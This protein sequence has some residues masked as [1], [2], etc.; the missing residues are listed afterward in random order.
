AL[1]PGARSGQEGP[2]EL[3]ERADG[4]VGLVGSGAAG[5]RVQDRLHPDAPGAPDVGLEA[6]AHHH[7]LGGGEAEPGE[8]DPEER[9]FRL[10][11]DLRPPAAG[12]RHRLDDRAAPGEEVAPLDRQPRIDVRRD[13]P[14]AGRDRARRRREPRVREVEVVADRHDRRLP[15]ALDGEH[16]VPGGADDR[17]H[18]VGPDHEHARAPVALADELPEDLERRQDALA[19]GL[20]AERREPSV[21]VAR[22]RAR[23]VREEGDPPRAPPELGD[24]LGGARRHLGAGPDAAVEV[25]DDAA[26]LGQA[27]AAGLSARAASSTGPNSWTRHRRSPSIAARAARSPGA[28]SARRSM[29]RPGRSTP[30]SR[31]SRSAAAARHARRAWTRRRTAAETAGRGCRGGWGSWSAGRPSP[32][33]TVDR[34]ASPQRSR[35]RRV[36]PGIAASTA[37]LPGL[38]AAM[39]R[40]VSL[41]RI[42]NGGRPVASAAASRNAWSSRRIARARGGSARAPLMSK[43]ASGSRSRTGG[44]WAARAAHSSSTQASRAIARSS[45]SRRSRSGMR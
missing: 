33:A 24:Q 29:S 27:H 18:F 6:V 12:D 37:A 10:A 34:I 44:S 39:S 30:G 1:R 14:G 4:E 31:A 32:R 16:L 3:D 36:Q 41:P 9:R 38:A 19:V 2:A 7:R 42:L 35:T 45:S 26:R 8:R 43:Y 11:R 21:D 25:E 15:V 17:G 5:G 23:V 28:A 20:D 40:S 13:E 22:R